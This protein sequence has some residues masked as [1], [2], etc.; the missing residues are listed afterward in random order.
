M[1]RSNIIF[2]WGKALGTTGQSLSISGSVGRAIILVPLGLTYAAPEQQ[3]TLD[4]R[5]TGMF[6]SMLD[7]PVTNHFLG[8]WL[9]WCDWSNCIVMIPVSRLV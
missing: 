8:C 6:W 3:V 5:E 2:R 7:A 9:R 1:V 4:K